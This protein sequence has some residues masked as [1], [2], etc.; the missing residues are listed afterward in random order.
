MEEKKRKH[1]KTV[2]TKVN[3]R[4]QWVALRTNNQRLIFGYLVA[5]TS[6]KRKGIICRLERHET[7][8][9]KELRWN[10][11]YVTNDELATFLRLNTGI[12]Q[13]ACRSTIRRVMNHLTKVKYVVIH[14][15]HLQNKHYALR[16]VE[17]LWDDKKHTFIT[18]FFSEMS[19][20]SGAKVES[21]RS[22][23]GAKVESSGAKVDIFVPVTTETYSQVEPQ[24]DQKKGAY[25]NNKI[26]NN[27]N[28]EDFTAKK[29][30]D[31]SFPSI[32]TEAEQQS[33]N[34]PRE[35]PN[36]SSSVPRETLKENNATM[37]SMIPGSN[38]HDQS[39]LHPAFQVRED[40]Q[41][42][43]FDKPAN[44]WSFWETKGVAEYPGLKRLAREFIAHVKA[45][46]NYDCAFI[47]EAENYRRLICP[48]LR[49]DLPLEFGEFP[50]DL[51]SDQLTW[52]PENFDLAMTGR[53]Y[54]VCPDMFHRIVT[55]LRHSPRGVAY[56]RDTGAYWHPPVMSMALDYS[57]YTK[58]SK[59]T[60]S[61]FHRD[62]SVNHIK[63]IALANQLPEN[64]VNG[65]MYSGMYFNIVLKRQIFW[66]CGTTA[67]TR[68]A[69]EELV[70]RFEQ[71]L[72]HNSKT[73]IFAQYQKKVKSGD[74]GEVNLIHWF[75]DFCFRYHFNGWF[76]AR[77]KN[78]EGVIMLSSLGANCD[79]SGSASGTIAY[80][81]TP[82]GHNR[83]M[84]FTYAQW[85]LYEKFKKTAQTNNIGQGSL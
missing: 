84:Y 56:Y 74:M 44:L 69:L 1:R 72:V 10:G 68:E 83:E 46:Y 43:R 32:K 77:I 22:T 17:V 36:D 42:T 55:F 80:I 64:E 67:L 30:G 21:Y 18:P 5:K 19:N 31:H 53:I 75:R 40:A 73:M 8:T 39:D 60:A 71:D 27:Q 78:D 81:P 66:L 63:E 65:V 33:S 57:S 48:D 52:K 49:M 54:K 13:E 47:F 15:Q 79:T 61:K 24:N 23:S 34:V 20:S 76:I 4:F 37:S 58:S 41:R 62:A 12:A 51:Y 3:P 16:A 59:T 25:I 35:T 9:E 85:R 45:A 14:G 6:T 26:I 50:D 29:S 2:I 70:Q 82:W 11:I 38:F 28:T 7:L